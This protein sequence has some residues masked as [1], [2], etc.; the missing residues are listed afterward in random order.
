M[1]VGELA[2]R[3]AILEPKNVIYE[4]KRFIGMKYDEVKAICKAMPYE[5]KKGK[6]G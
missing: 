2:K 5:T 3:K 4:V 6:D 1:L